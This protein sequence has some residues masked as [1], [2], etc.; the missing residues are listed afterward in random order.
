MFKNILFMGATT[1][2]KLLSGVGVFLIFTRILSPSDYGLVVYH[3]S[4][5][6]MLTLVIDYGY[7][8]YLVKHAGENPSEIKS[9][10]AEALAAKVYLI[11]GY[12]LIGL[13]LFPVGLLQKDNAV[14]FIMLAIAALF[15]TFGDFFNLSFRCIQKFHKESVNSI[16]VSVTHLICILVIALPYKTVNAVAISFVLS[17]F[18]YMLISW[19]S[20][21]RQFGEWGVK[22]ELLTNRK[23]ILSNY[24][25]V[26]PYS[27]DSFLVNIRSY[28]DVVI[29]NSVLGSAAVGLYQAGMNIVKSIEVL[30]P[31]FANVYLPKLSSLRSE[32]KKCNQVYMQLF[33]IMFGGGVALF[34]MFYLVNED[35]ISFVLGDKYIACTA[36]FPLFGVFL[37]VRFVT[38]SQGVIVTALGFQKYRMFAGVLALSVLI[39][40][41]IF[42][43]RWLGVEGAIIANII[44]T[45]TLLIYFA[46]LL[47]IKKIKLSA[48]VWQLA[49]FSILVLLFLLY[50]VGE[51]T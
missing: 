33:Y 37:L 15:S 32:M 39:I 45:M 24:K 12:V 41:S 23:I 26:F 25:E 38:V 50:V 44:A 5:G 1:F 2:I 47:S 10:F 35:I 22:M 16:I 11:V 8:T 13:I 51:Q 17:R 4:V 48:G 27:M 30:A 9:I 28:I 31:I 42:M 46:I 14:L 21:K 34:L 40:T 43:S 6:M 19:W 49:L 20:Y 7:S 18:I 36:F 29:V 3:F